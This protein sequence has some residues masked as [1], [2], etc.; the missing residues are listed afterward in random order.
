MNDEHHEAPSVQSSP[1]PVLEEGGNAAIP[2]RPHGFKSALTLLSIY[3]I[4]FRDASRF[5][6]P[7]GV[8]WFG[9]AGSLIALPVFLLAMLLQWAL[10]PSTVAL[11]CLALSAVMTRM[12]HW[13]GLADVADAWWGGATPLRRQEIM[14][15]TAIGSFALVT[16]A[17]TLMGTYL[18]LYNVVIA[19]RFLLLLVV[20]ILARI[21]VTFAA[22][23]LAPAKP[24][25]LAASIAGNVSAGGI[26]A[27]I[28]ALLFALLCSVVSVGWLGLVIC[29]AILIG[30]Y[31]LARVVAKRMGGATGDVYGATI[32]LTEL[33]GYALFMLVAAVPHG[34]ALLAML[35]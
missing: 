1:S 17:L 12:M 8:G 35:H 11:L 5:S 23:Y 34:A 31:L 16:V 29:S 18:A 27:M 32:V 7:A 4:R 19:K 3:P 28:T 14:S 24:R 22:K 26:A 33:L 15:D 20:P 9:W 25:G 13:D 6:Y 21:V 10:Q 2:L 30:G